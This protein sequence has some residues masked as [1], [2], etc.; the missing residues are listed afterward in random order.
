MKKFTSGRKSVDT[1]QRSGRPVK[2]QRQFQKMIEKMILPNGRVTIEEMSLKFG[3][4]VSTFHKIIQDDLNF[5][6]NHV[7]Q[8]PK[9]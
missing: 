2:F 6:K 4:N 1:E 5:Q 9:M 7:R 8:V 3:V